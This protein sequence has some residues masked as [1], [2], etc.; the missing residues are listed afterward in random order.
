MLILGHISSSTDGGQHRR[1]VILLV[2]EIEINCNPVKASSISPLQSGNVTS[3]SSSYMLKRSIFCIDVN[4]ALYCTNKGRTSW[5]TPSPSLSLPSDPSKRRRRP[6]SWCQ[7]L[8]SSP[9]NHTSLCAVAPLHRRR[10]RRRRHL[11]DVV[12]RMVRL[13]PP[14]PPSSLNRLPLLKAVFCLLSEYVCECFVK[15]VHQRNTLGDCG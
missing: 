11:V 7:L 12:C 9:R 13:P 8:S 2:N 3:I 4:F 14:P 15:A 5:R 6:H 10:R 1:I